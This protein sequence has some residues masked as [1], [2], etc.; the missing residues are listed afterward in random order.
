MMD[1]VCNTQEVAPLWQTEPP[2]VNSTC[3]T[4]V[5][6]EVRTCVDCI[7]LYQFHFLFPEITRKEDMWLCGR[8]IW[9]V[10]HEAGVPQLCDFWILG[11]VGCVLVVIGGNSIAQ[12]FLLIF[13]IAYCTTQY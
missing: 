5:E 12:I 3:E 6:A 9:L 7:D 8:E 4:V 10:C 11:T 1:G 2:P 13:Q